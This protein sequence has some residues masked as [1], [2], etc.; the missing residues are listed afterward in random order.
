MIKEGQT[1]D[2]WEEEKE[3]DMKKQQE[4]IEQLDKDLGNCFHP[5]YSCFIEYI[6]YFPKEHKYISLYTTNEMPE[7]VMKKR[8]ELR[9]IV[10]T[11][12]LSHANFK[13]REMKMVDKQEEVDQ[14][15]NNHLF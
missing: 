5:M 14:V 3:N 11:Q 2:E 8:E 12:R 6:M 10:N 7:E 15:R 13:R 9:E 1:I 4:V